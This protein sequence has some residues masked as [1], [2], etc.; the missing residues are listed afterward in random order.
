MTVAMHCNLKAPVVMGFNYEARNAPAYK[1]NSF[2]FYDPD[3]HLGIN[4]WRLV[5]V[6]Q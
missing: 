3:F 2:G 1:F 4:I 6:Y 5:L